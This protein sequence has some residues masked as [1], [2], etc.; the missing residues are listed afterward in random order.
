MST[1]EI[2]ETAKVDPE[3]KQIR[4]SLIN[5]QSCILPQ[6]YKLVGDELSITDDIVLRGN[7]IVLRGNRI[8]LPAKLQPRAI[9][10][11]HEN[12]RWYNKMQTTNTFQIVVAQD[13]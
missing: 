9:A 7:R 4:E 13:G 11:A 12:A 5:N 8:V 6:D 2:R 1:E 10:L 3:M